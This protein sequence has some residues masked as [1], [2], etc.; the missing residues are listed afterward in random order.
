MTLIQLIADLRKTA[1]RIRRRGHLVTARQLKIWQRRL[2]RL[3]LRFESLTGRQL[4]RQAV[5]LGSAAVLALGLSRPAHAAGAIRFSEVQDPGITLLRSG[6]GDDNSHV[7]FADFDGD[8]DLDAVGV[9]D[10]GYILYWRNEG[11]TAQPQWVDKTATPASPFDGMASGGHDYKSVTVGDID[12]DGDVDVLIGNY[13]SLRF[14]RNTGTAMA[15]AFQEET[16]AASPFYGSIGDYVPAYTVGNYTYGPYYYSSYTS[17]RPQLVDLDGDGD[18]DLL[19]AEYGDVRYFENT[20]SAAAPAFTERTGSANPLDALTHYGVDYLWL[21]AGDLDGD[22]DPDLLAGG[23]GSYDLQLWRNTG[24]RTAPAFSNEGALPVLHPYWMPS[25][26]D[27]DGD[28]DLDL[29]TGFWNAGT[30]NFENK[31]GAASPKFSQPIPYFAIYDSILRADVDSDGD[32][33][34]LQGVYL[35]RNNGGV[36]QFEAGSLFENFGS[37]DARAFGDLDGDGDLDFVVRD[38]GYLRYFRKDGA[39]GS[40]G[41]SEQYN[42]TN[43]F[44]GNYI[45][46]NNQD[47]A[48]LIDMDGDGDLDLVLGVY[49]GGN[50]S[51]QYLHNEGTAT[52]PEFDLQIG[53][54]DPFDGIVIPRYSRPMLEDLD[55]DGDIDFF[56][57]GYYLGDDKLFLSDGPAVTPNLVQQAGFF[58]DRTIQ[59]SQVFTDLDNDGDIDIVTWDWGTY[60]FRLIRND[61][62]RFTKVD[63]IAVAKDKPVLGPVPASSGQEICV[64]VPSVANDVNVELFNLAGERVQTGLSQITGGNACIMAPPAPGLYWAKITVDGKTSMQKIIIKP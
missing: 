5:S 16:G 57:V 58:A 53:S 1:R 39:A 63:P 45:G 56:S 26:A 36:F 3:K 18:L 32:L 59:G 33:D 31:G 30:Q 35:W 8:G 29:F 44:Y 4:R 19:V 25:L 21:A 24:T 46:Y 61:S 34:I 17:S 9:N 23:S 64:F 54:T 52:A 41:F 28:G 37:Q 2:Q 42:A 51:L 14:F 48:R 55:K 47:E 60:S 13:D 50:T 15:P 10:G 38:G 49:G 40:L 20:G 6:Y 62:D 12:G 11:S 22:G 27:Y 43:P 7:A